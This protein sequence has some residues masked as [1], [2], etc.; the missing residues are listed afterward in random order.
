MAQL[1]R[2]I[3]PDQD[4]V[5]PM[6]AARTRVTSTTTI[7]ATRGVTG[8][9]GVPSTGNIHLA[10]PPDSLRLSSLNVGTKPVPNLNLPKRP[11]PYS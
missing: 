2:L 10:L 3:E 5:Q 1:S 4:E 8:P 6:H 11:K 7:T 9:I